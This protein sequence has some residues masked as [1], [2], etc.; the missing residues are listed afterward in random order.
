MTLYYAPAVFFYL[1]GRCI[2]I[3]PASKGTVA[4]DVFIKRFL[5]LGVTVI[6]CFVI[7][8]WPFWVFAKKDVKPIDSI[9]QVLNRQ[10]P[11][12]RG[13]FEGKVSNIWCTLSTKP[14]SIRQRLPASILP[15]LALLLTVALLIPC[16]YS[17]FSAVSSFQMQ[18]KKDC[19]QLE[20]GRDLRLLLLGSSSSALSFFLASFQVH[21]KSILLALSP[22]S[23]MFLEYPYFVS[24]FSIVATWT[25]WPLMQ[26]DNLHFAYFI[27]IAIFS[28]LLSV[29]KTDE[30]FCKYS[31]SLTAT[32]DQV[33]Q[34]IQSYVIPV[35]ISLM[36]IL[37]ILEVFVL[38]PDNLPDIFAVLW[39][40]VGCLFFCLS[41]IYCT[42]HLFSS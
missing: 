25:M 31:S 17:L 12:Q 34:I 36:V 38:P 39:S 20:E 19:K 27:C 33:H 1:L 40:I 8:W 10:F 22:L 41:L 14:F 26:V 13:L 9:L 6:S 30:I 3:N 16:C 11:F 15:L 5:M 24:W 21:E 2:E 18:T 29:F 4:I 7:L 23:L 42:I 28:C 37:H 32:W 35:S